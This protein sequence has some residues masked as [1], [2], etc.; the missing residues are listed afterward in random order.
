MTDTISQIQAQLTALQLE[1]KDLRSGYLTVNRRYTVTIESLRDLTNHA[2]EAAKFSSQASLKSVAAAKN[3]VNATV[4]AVEHGIFSA[5]DFAAKSAEDA[6]EAAALAAAATAAA[7]SAAAIAVAHQAEE[8]AI[9][10]SASA[11]EASKIAAGAAAEAIKISNQASALAR[12]ARAK[13]PNWLLPMAKTVKVFASNLSAKVQEYCES[14]G[15]YVAF[16]N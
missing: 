15:L 9:L 2:S 4:D 11:A 16:C 10:A 13:T 6:A 5:V 8:S 14:Q 12:N 3:A 1:V 7:A